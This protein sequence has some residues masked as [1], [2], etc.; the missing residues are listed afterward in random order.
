MQFVAL[1]VHQFSIIH[2][3]LIS[4]S[5]ALQ[6]SL[7]LTSILFD[8]DMDLCSS[9]AH[10]PRTVLRISPIEHLANTVAVCL[11][12]IVLV[13]F[14]RFLVG[15][16][17]SKHLGPSRVSYFI[18]AITMSCEPGLVVSSVRVLRSGT[19][20]FAGV[21]VLFPAASLLI[22]LTISCLIALAR[23]CMLREWRQLG[24]PL[25]PHGEGHIFVIGF[26]IWN[27]GFM[28]HHLVRSVI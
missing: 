8:F 18:F 7:L 20:V 2:V 26:L 16:H 3:H 13:S 24:H 4:F 22:A 23:F 9:Q 1:F 14:V 21:A 28:N 27:I 5:W 19:H 6:P 17:C 12:L 25:E 10:P 15:S 11:I